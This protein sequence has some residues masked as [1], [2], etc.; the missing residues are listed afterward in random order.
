MS[1]CEGS[2]VVTLQTGEKQENNRYVG[3]KIHCKQNTL[4]HKSLLD[5]G[6]LQRFGPFGT[7]SAVLSCNTESNLQHFRHCVLN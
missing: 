6:F 5:T 2:W 7:G 4:W 1:E 3:G